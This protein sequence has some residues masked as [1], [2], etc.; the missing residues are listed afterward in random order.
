MIQFSTLNKF[1]FQAIAWR[2]GEGPKR[3][4]PRSLY[5]PPFHGGSFESWPR[6]PVTPTCGFLWPRLVGVPIS[7]TDPICSLLT[8]SNCIDC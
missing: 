3:M 8:Y 5:P 4:K 1:E 2:N 7:R 6:V